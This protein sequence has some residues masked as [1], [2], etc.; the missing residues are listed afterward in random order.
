MAKNLP[1]WIVVWIAVSTLIVIYDASFVLL[2]PR[3]LEGGD[4]SFLFSG[5]QFS[6]QQISRHKMTLFVALDILYS[7]IDIKYGDMEDHFV[8]AQSMYS[9]TYK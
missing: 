7:T 1:T 6:A 5:R 9:A 4:L 3:T 2:R 8:I